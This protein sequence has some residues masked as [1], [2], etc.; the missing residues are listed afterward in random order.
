VAWG[1]AL[2]LLGAFCISGLLHTLIL[3]PDVPDLTYGA[4]A[5]DPFAFLGVL[6]V[7]AAVVAIAAFLPMRRATQVQAAVALRNE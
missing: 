1:A 7:L 6:S 3:L 2:G 5:F 4:G